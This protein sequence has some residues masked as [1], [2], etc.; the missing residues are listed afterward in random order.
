MNVSFMV[1]GSPITGIVAAESTAYP[2]RTNHVGSSAFRRVN[3]LLLPRT[4]PAVAA[5]P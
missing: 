1:S 5:S 2:R 4:W 3:R